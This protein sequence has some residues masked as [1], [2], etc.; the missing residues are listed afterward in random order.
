MYVVDLFNIFKKKD[1][2]GLIGVYSVNDCLFV[3]VV[4]YFID[5]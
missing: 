3:E 1:V 4:F 5:C 2:K